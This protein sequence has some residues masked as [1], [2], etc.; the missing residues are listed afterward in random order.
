MVCMGGV[1][2]RAGR[3]SGLGREARQFFLGGLGAGMV[4]GV[5]PVREFL[6]FTYC[7]VLDERKIW[8][9]GKTR[10]SEGQHILTLMHT[11]IH[12]FIQRKI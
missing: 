9:Q 8:I 11:F 5:C 3:S 7:T 1:Y 10:G 6:H 2:I 12:S 4:Y